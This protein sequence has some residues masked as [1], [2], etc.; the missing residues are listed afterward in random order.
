M[1][2]P[3]YKKDVNMN[4]FL[5]NLFCLLLFVLPLCMFSQDF[6][7]KLIDQQTK[8][9]I[10]FASMIVDNK[11]FITNEDGYVTV[12]FFEKTIIQHVSY[13]TKTIQIGQLKDS[14]LVT[15]ERKDYFLP[16]LTVK[17]ID[18]KYYLKLLTK[19]IDKYRAEAILCDLNYAY[20]LETKDVIYKEKIKALINVEYQPRKGFHLP[21]NY[22]VAGSFWFME[23]MPF[24]NINTEYLLLSY[25]PFAIRKVVDKQYM[26]SNRR[27]IKSIK[28]DLFNIYA[29]NDSIVKYVFTKNDDNQVQE[30]IVNQNTNQIKEI[31]FKEKD[32]NAFTNINDT[33][34]IT[35][36][37]LEL[38]YSYENQNSIPSA[39][40]FNMEF[41]YLDVVYQIRGFLRLHA[42]PKDDIH[43]I[44]LGPVIPPNIYQRIITN[45]IN[46]K[47]IDSVFANYNYPGFKLSEKLGLQRNNVDNT[48][49]VDMFFNRQNGLL[50]WNKKGVANDDYHCKVVD[51]LIYQS[52]NS[53]R[54]YETKLGFI[55]TFNLERAGSRWNIKSYPTIMDNRN[56][57]FYL[58][59]ADALNSTFN[60]DLLFDYI[61]SQRQQCL[62]SLSDMKNLSPKEIKVFLQTCYKE[63]ISKANLTCYKILHNDFNLDDQLKLNLEIYNQ[64]GIDRF[65]TLSKKLI[66][67]EQTM[68][69]FYNYL[70]TSFAQLNRKATYF[71]TNILNQYIRH[72]KKII[73][74]ISE[75][76]SIDDKYIGGLYLSLAQVYYDLEDIETSCNCVRTA[77]KYWP[78]GYDEAKKYLPFLIDTVLQNCISNQ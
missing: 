73:E 55:W 54:T 43:T 42:T 59:H 38:Q 44:S 2:F 37:D 5:K 40:T 22:L 26:F 29:P 7:L 21:N 77:K 49:N 69:V 51:N 61:E 33:K 60:V 16:E 24:F 1:K 4:Q 58:R 34:K 47:I 31:N 41:T 9:P 30:I 6:R 62:D 23:E 53:L 10:S 17:P 45:K 66:I 3:F 75:N 71:D 18:D 12:P 20:Y 11:L 65:E 27:K 35:I 48:Q 56:T 25:D 13:K 50:K 78:K 72:S 8:K 28:R 64:L 15:L 39:L 19:I 14:Y 67:N 32:L 74:I 68:K 70:Q 46:S 57:I 52:Q 76:D 36:S 63:T